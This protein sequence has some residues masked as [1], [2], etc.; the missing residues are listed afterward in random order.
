MPWLIAILSSLT[1]LL[2]VSRLG[3]YRAGRTFAP[4]GHFIEVDGVRLHY[5][6]AGTGPVLVLLH[7]AST[8]LRDFSASIFEPLSRHHRVIAVD[9]PGHGF[10]ARPKGPWPDP[11]R[12]AELIH[13]LLGALSV[14]RPVMV[15]HS[16]SGAVVLAYLL[17]Y[18]GQAAGGVL[19]AGATHP[20]TGGVA[21]YNRLACVPLIGRLFSSTLVYPLGRLLLDTAVSE[22]FAPNPVPDGYVQRTGVPLSLRPDAFRANAEDIHYLSDFLAEQSQRYGEIRQP[23]LLLTGSDD[24]IVP[25]RNHCDRLA[26]QLPGAVRIELEATG[27]ALHHTRSDRI[28]N[29]IAAFARQQRHDPHIVAPTETMTSD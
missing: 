1:A 7:G 25:P 2:L 3:A 14:E 13:G 23:L 10:S 28:V 6:E 26:A 19:L 4:Q 5:R 8:S 12:Q 21:W 22:V 20:W 18:P 24:S 9:R 11:A 29:L 16:W 15:G 27:H 17:A